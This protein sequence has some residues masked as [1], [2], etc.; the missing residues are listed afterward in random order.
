VIKGDKEIIANLENVLKI[1]AKTQVEALEEVGQRGVGI[2]K[3]NTPVD[4]GRLRNSMGYTV[5]NKVEGGENTVNRTSEKDSVYLGTNV[6]YAP[7]V[8]YRSKNGSQGFMLRSFNQL[9]PIAKKIIEN[10]FKGAIR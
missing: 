2:L 8:E 6:I 10:S 1:V 5:A 4:T 9:V 3:L 7:S